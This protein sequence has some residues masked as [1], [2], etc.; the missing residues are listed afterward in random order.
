MGGNTVKRIVTAGFLIISIL[1]LL[2][3]C[4]GG[5]GGGSSAPTVSGTAS[6]GA[7][8]LGQTVKLKDANGRS[9]V[10]TTTNGTTGRYSIDVTGLT[11]PFIVTVT[12]TNGTYVSLAPTAGTANINPIT[13]TVVALAA[14]TSDVSALFLNLTPAQVTTINANYIAKSG[15]LTT[16]LQTALLTGVNA[17]AYFTGT[18]TAGTGIDALFDTY[19]ITIGLNTGITITT[20]GASPTTVL[21][22]PVAT[23]T[24]NTSQPLP[25]LATRAIVD[26]ALQQ[27]AIAKF[28]LTPSPKLAILGFHILNDIAVSTT[29]VPTFT[30]NY[31]LPVMLNGQINS[32]DYTISMISAA[33][34]TVTAGQNLF[35]VTYTL[36]TG[37][38]QFSI[39]PNSIQAGTFLT[40]NSVTYV[41]LVPS[42]F[43]LTV[44]YQ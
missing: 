42:D 21:T 19:L 31:S 40:S 3:A 8:I 2:V 25:V 4:G 17:A 10:D 9:A 41:T 32:T 24:A 30:N 26:I 39:D 1:T 14:A 35:R 15:L 28:A 11:A 20:K 6:E 29:T 12:G 18:I 44:T 23:I 5:G 16:S 37:G 22:I 27:S 34:E 43:N 36:V 38:P 7:L 13:T 33:G